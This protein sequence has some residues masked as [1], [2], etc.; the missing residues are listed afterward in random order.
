YALLAVVLRNRV[1]NIE[2]DSG[3]RDLLQIAFFTTIGLSVRMD[4]LRKGGPGL[5]A[6][7]AAASLGAVLQDLLGIGLARAMGIDARIGILAGSVSLTGG[8][9]TSLVWGREFEKLGVHGA[10]TVAVAAAT[11]GITVSGLIGGFIGG[12]LIRRHKLVSKGKAALLAA[13]SESA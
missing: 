7:L 3:L 10:T 9:A 5:V 6:L 1:L 13:E 2:A 12:R 11:F 4:S 8:P